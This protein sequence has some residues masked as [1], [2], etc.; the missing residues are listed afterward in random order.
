MF[1]VAVWCVFGLLDVSYNTDVYNT[2]V[3]FITE[4]CQYSLT[5]N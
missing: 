1:M 2:D 3:C 5:E 4:Q